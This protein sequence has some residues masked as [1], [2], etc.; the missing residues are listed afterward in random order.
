MKKMVLTTACVLTGLVLAGCGSTHQGSSQQGGT[1][2][3]GPA[4]KV[5]KYSSLPASEQKAIVEVSSHYG[6]AHPKVIQVTQE[7]T[8]PDQNLMYIVKLDGQFNV[9]GFKSNDLSFSIMGDGSKAWNITN[10]AGKF[11]VDTLPLN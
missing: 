6:D 5:V 10:K 11:N 4:P 7:V 9:S 3:S 8:E 1:Q 2:Q